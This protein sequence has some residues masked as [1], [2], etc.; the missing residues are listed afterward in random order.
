MVYKSIGG[1]KDSRGLD[2]RGARRILSMVEEGERAQGWRK[3]GGNA[4]CDVTSAFVLKGSVGAV[5]E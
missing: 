2:Y 1:L 3:E 5:V 4:V